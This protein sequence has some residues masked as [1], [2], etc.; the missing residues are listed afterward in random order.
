MFVGTHTAVGGGRWRRAIS[1][2][3]VVGAS[4]VVAVSRPAPVH[5]AGDP[6]IA[7]TADVQVDSGLN[8]KGALATSN[9]ALSMAPDQAWLAGDR[10]DDATIPEYATYPQHWGRLGDKLQVVP[11]NHEIK[12]GPTMPGYLATFPVQGLPLPR[13]ET[14]G[15]WRVYFLDS[16][17]SAAVGSPSYNF[18]QADLAVHPNQPIA[19]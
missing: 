1:A 15:A 3:L 18:V 2:A 12:D 10:T 14:I 5:A 4:V 11:G 7:A 8:I 16:N 13:A 19:A 6:V 17:L 9:L